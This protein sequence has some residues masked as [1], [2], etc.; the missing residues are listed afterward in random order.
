MKYTAKVFKKIWESNH[1]PQFMWQLHSYQNSGCKLTWWLVR[2][3]MQ[4][5]NIAWAQE[6][7][8]SLG[9]IA[10]PLTQNE[11][12]RKNK[13]KQKKRIAWR[14]ATREDAGLTW[15][16]LGEWGQHL[17]NKSQHQDR[18]THQQIWILSHFSLS[19]H[20][21]ILEGDIAMTLMWRPENSRETRDSR[22][23][24]W[25]P[26]VQSCLLYSSPSPRD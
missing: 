8:T 14:V 12:N 10:R 13:N 6:F 5:S 19:M 23:T 26:G 17:R 16:T 2:R 9:Y 25:A 24:M 11:T 7:G 22:S 18:G 21:F 4:N 1:T 20:I 3:L 15:W